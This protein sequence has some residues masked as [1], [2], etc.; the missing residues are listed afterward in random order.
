ML[1]VDDIGT[2]EDS[3]LMDPIVLEACGHRLHE[4]C[5]QRLCARRNWPESSVTCPICRFISAARPQESLGETT[6]RLN[7]A[8]SQEDQPSEVSSPDPGLF[9][10]QLDLNNLT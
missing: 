2:E 1:T 4:K 6:S 5:C 9:S 3:I 10:Q 7:H 8:Q